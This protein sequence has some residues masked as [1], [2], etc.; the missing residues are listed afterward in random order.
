MQNSS[1]FR[2]FSDKQTGIDLYGKFNDGYLE[3]AFNS[4]NYKGSLVRDSSGFFRINLFDSNIDLNLNSSE[5]ETL[6]YQLKFR[7]TGENLD[8]NELNLILLIFII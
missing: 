1:S 7:F 2:F 8:L 3:L 6:S 5:E 4:D